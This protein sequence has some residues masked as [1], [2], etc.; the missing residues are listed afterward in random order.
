MTDA[1]PRLPLHIKKN[2]GVRPWAILPGIVI[3]LVL[4]LA[5]MIASKATLEDMLHGSTIYIVLGVLVFA[6]LITYF[7]RIPSQ[8]DIDQ[9]GIQLISKKTHYILAW[10]DIAHATPIPGAVRV[11]IKGRPDEEG[12]LI[13]ERFGVKSADLTALIREGMERWGASPSSG[14]ALSPRTTL[15]PG[16]GKAAS[17]AGLR[18]ML[19]FIGAGALA[20]ILGV[21]VWQGADYFKTTQLR[22]HGVRTEGTVVRIYTS[23]CGKRSCSLDVEYAYSTPDGRR[24]RGFGYLTSDDDLQDPDYLYAKSHR[25]IPIVFDA[26]HPE[27][28]ETNFRDWV[29]RRDA[30]GMMF[31]II[32]IFAGVVAVI[33]SIIAGS[34]VLAIRKASKV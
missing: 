19:F 3:V 5:P 21:V 12:V 29:F 1:K 32:G 6:A 16:G 23:G 11:E 17:V 28:V 7:V 20:M 24:L 31:T 14:V 10:P 4:Q 26:T 30:L 27:T 25:T 8:L 34:I 13:S 18:R 15:P 2:I 22:A 9:S 33:F